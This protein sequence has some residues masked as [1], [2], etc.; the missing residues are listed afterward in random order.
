MIQDLFA[1]SVDRY[2]KNVAILAGDASVTYEEL[3]ENAN[4]LANR[5]LSLG[6]MKGDVVAILVHNRVSA[7]MSIVATLK[8]GMAFV[9]LDPGI[10]TKRL[11]LMI[12]DIR[13]RLFLVESSMMTRLK[14][15]GCIP[16][17]ASLL[18]LDDEAPSDGWRGQL[19]VVSRSWKQSKAERPQVAYGPD[20]MCYI[21]FT[22][23]STGRPKPIAGRL[24]GIDHFIK[25][26]IETLGLNDQ[27]RGSQLLPLS[28]DPS[29]REI[30]APL[31]CGGTVCVPA[32]PQVL[33][34]ASALADWINRQRLE[35]AQFVPSLLRS[36]LSAQLSQDDF[37]SLKYVLS[38]GE[39]LLPGDVGKWVK[40]F[41]DRI[42][43]VN[44][45]GP[46][47]T[48]MAKFFY[49]VK[50]SDKDKASIPIGKPMPGA[51]AVVVGKD[52]A[53]C[54]PKVIGEIYIRTPYRSLGYYN[55]PE[56]TKQVFVQNP[57]SDESEDLV[58]KSGD[59]GRILDDGNFECLGRKDDQVKIRGV[60]IELREIEDCLLKHEDLKEVAVVDREDRE[61]QKYLCA[62]VV[63][64]KEVARGQLRKYLTDFFPE[65]MVPSQIVVMEQLPLTISGKVDRR[66]LP[67]PEN[68]RGKRKSAEFELRTPVE[69]VLVGIWKEVLGVR[70]LNLDDDFFE[71]GGHS[72]LATQ[73]LSR[74]RDVFQVAIPLKEIFEDATVAALA[75]AVERERGIAT[76]RKTPPIQHAGRDQELP[77]SF[78]Q[79]RLW[80]LHQLA[81]ADV[82]YNIGQ[83]VRLPGE[84][85]IHAIWQGLLELVNRHEVLRTRFEVLN[86]HPVQVIEPPRRV[87]LPLWDISSLP[88]T[89][90]EALA[91]T[92][93]WAVNQRPFDLE[94]GPVWRAAVLRKSTEDHLMPLSVHHVANDGW[95]MVLLVSEFKEI[96][97]PYHEG[98][99]PALPEL[100]FQY[101][102]FSAW[103][104]EWLQ[105]GV[106]ADLLEYWKRQLAEAPVL[107][108]PRNSLRHIANPHGARVPFRLS[109]NLN[110]GLTKLSRQVGVTTFMTLLAGLQIVLA[111]YT[112]QE[113]IAI[114]VPIAGRNRSDLEKVVGLFV[115]TLVM[116][117][118]VG[119]NPT[120]RELLGRVRHV[121][122]EAYAHQDA[123][124]EKVVEELRPGRSLGWDDPFQ[125][126][127]V[128]QNMPAA[129][130]DAQKRRITGDWIW[131][132]S[133]KFAMTLSLMKGE[134]NISGFLEY[135]E[136]LFD[137]TL[138]VR[139]LGHLENIFQGMLISGIDRRVK[140]IRMLREEEEAQVLVEWSDG[141]ER[142]EG[143]GSLGELFEAQVERTPDAAA[144]EYEDEEISYGE[145]NERGEELA[146]EL[147]ELGV[148]GEV[149]VGICME[150]GLEMMVG[151]VGVMKAGGSYVAVEGRNPGERVRSILEDAGARVVVTD[152]RM[153][154]R[155]PKTVRAVYVGRGKR[156]GE[157]ETRGK[158]E[159]KGRRGGVISGNEAYVMYT[160]GSTGRARGVVI[161]Q[162]GVINL[163]EAMAERVYGRGR[164]G[165]RV[166]L[167]ASLVFDASVKQI[168]RLMYGDK[169][170]IV[171]ESIRG[172]GE[173]LKRFLS[174]VPGVD[175]FDCTPTQIRAVIEAGGGELPE[176]FRG[177]VVIGGEELDE[178]SVEAV[179]GGEWRKCHNVYGPTECTNTA[180][181]GDMKRGEEITI[182]RPLGGVK[183]YVV[184]SEGE[185]VPIGVKGELNIGGAG[186]ARGY[187]GEAR[188]T[189]VRFVPDRFGGRIGGRVYRTGDLVSWEKKGQLRYEGRADEQ[190]KIRGYRVEMGEIEKVLAEHAG[191]RECAVVARKNRRGD[192]VLVG[193]FVVAGERKLSGGELREYLRS[194]LPE[195]MVPWEYVEL[196]GLP[197][198]VNR[199]L[200]RRELKRKW[201]EGQE[202]GRK[203]KIE[204]PTPVE[205]MLMEMW[206]EV[207]G[208]DRIGREEN[209]FELG[210]HSLL[211]TQVISRVRKMFEVEV[212]LT[213]L[214]ERPTIAG[215][216]EAVERELGY[217][218]GLKTGAIERVSREG[219]ILLS[220]SQQRMWFLQELEPES[221]AYN[222][223]IG[224]RIGGRF[225]ISALEQSLGEVVRRHEVLRTRFEC[226]EGHAAQVIDEE[227]GIGAPIVDLSAMEERHRN[228]LA[229]RLAQQEGRRSF[230]L[231][232]DPPIRTE[233]IR[234]DSGDNLL[235]LTLHHI[236][237]DG[238]ST[239][240][241]VREVVGLYKAWRNGER[242]GLTPLAIQYA[243]YSAWQ[244]SWLTR[245]VL[246]DQIEYWKQQLMDAPMLELPADRAR[247]AI[248]SHS[249]NSVRSNLPPELCTTLREV[250]RR[251]GVTLFMALLA[252]FQ[253]LLTRYT[254]RTDITVGSPVAGR[255]RAET[256]GLIGC[257]AN[258]LAMRLDTS[259]N[260]L[261]G[262]LLT[263]MRNVALAA[264]AH[265]DVP[266]EMVVEEVHPERSLSHEP[267][268]QAMFTMQPAS[269]PV[270]GLSECDI[271]YEAIEWK[272]SKLDIAMAVTEKGEQIKGRL[273][274]ATDL[275]D[276]V[277][278]ERFLGHFN[279]TLRWLGE[280]NGRG[281]TEFALMTDWEQEQVLVEWNRTGVEYEGPLCLPWLFEEQAERG[282]DRVAIVMGGDQVTYAALNERANQLGHYLR[283][284][285][286]RPEGRVGIR[287]ERSIS[288]LVAMLA[289]LKA[290]GAYVPLDPKYPDDRVKYMLRD[291]EVKI[292]IS[293]ADNEEV[294]E[295]ESRIKII[296][297][298]RDRKRIDERSGLNIGGNAEPGSLAYVI[299][300]SGS[301]GQPKGV[302]IT[303]GGAT[304]FLKWA[305]SAYPEDSLRAVLGSTSI[306]FDL[307]IFELFLPLCFGGKIV[308]VED[309]LDSQH[310][311]DREQVILINTV[312]S[313]LEGLLDLCRLPSCMRVVNVAGEALSADLVKRV[314]SGSAIERMH[315]LYGPT[316]TTT[317]STMKKI[318][319]SLGEEPTI[320]KPI[321]N[322]ELFVLDRN[323]QPVP[324]GVPGEIYIG[325]LG[326][327]RGYLNRPAQ[328]GERFVPKPF[329]LEAGTR[330]YRTG[331]VGRFGQGSEVE[332]LGRLDQQV[333]IRGYRIEPGEIET[334]LSSHTA[335]QQSA[336]VVRENGRGNKELIAYIVPTNE[337]DSACNDVRAYMRRKLPSYMVPSAF[338]LLDRMPLTPNGKL[339]RDALP[340]PKPL[341]TAAHVSPRTQVQ[342]IV[343]G[344]WG[345]LL[346]TETVGSDRSFFD[347]GGHSLL[348]TQ[349]ISRV[350]D[351][352]G[353]EVPLR[354]LFNTPTISGF[355]EAVE[356]ER[357]AGRNAEA[358]PI[359]PVP[360]DRTWPLSFAQQRLWF[361]QQLE[362]E[363]GLYN[364]PLGAHIDGP[365]SISALR[366][367]LQEVA[368]RHQ[369]LRTRFE[370]MGAGPV[371]V[372]DELPQIDLAVYDLGAL[373][374]NELD[375][376][377]RDIAQREAKRPFDLE[378]G[379]VWRAC[380][381]RCAPKEHVMLLYMHHVAGDG[382]SMG[383]L[384]KEITA[385]YDGY[386]EGRTVKLE[387]IP[388]QYV[389]YAMWQR[390]WL[391]GE[392]LQGAIDYWRHQLAGLSS[393]TLPTDHPRVVSARHK[394][395]KRMFS[396]SAD[397][398]NQIR[399]MSR[400]EGTTVFMTLLAAL[401]ALLGRYTGQD[402]VVVGT[403]VANRNR[404]ETEGLI[405]FFV[406][407]VVLRTDLS[408]N[409]SFRELLG[410]VRKTTLDAYGYQE[411]PFDRVVE[412]LNPQRSL[413]YTPIFQV[414]FV[415]EDARVERSVA[416]KLRLSPFVV[417]APA[418]G[419]DWVVTVRETKEGFTGVWRYREELFEPSTIE[420]ICLQ[421]QSLLDK[422]TIFPEA[423]LAELYT[424]VDA[425][426]NSRDESRPSA[427]VKEA[428]PKTVTLPVG[429]LVTKC[430]LSAGEDAPLVLNPDVEDFDP[431]EWAGMERAFI[432]D[433]LLE[434]GAILFRGFQIGSATDFERFVSAICPDLFSSYGDL[435]REEIGGYVYGSTPYPSDQPI[436]FHNESSHMHCWPLKIWFYCVTPPEQGGETPFVDC[437][438]LYEDMDP[439]LRQQFR[440]KGLMYVRNFG[441]GLDVS[442]QEFFKTTDPSAV[443]AFCQRAAIDWE[444]CAGSRLRTRK[445]CPAVGTHPKTGQSVFF[446]QLQ[447]HHISCLAGD[448]R[449]DLLNLFGEERLPR[450]VYYG[451][452]QR[453]PDTVVDELRHLYDKHAR[454][455]TWR[456]GDILMLDN[457]L[458]AH[459]RRPFSG[460][461]RI[462]VA[463]GEMIKATS[464]DPASAAV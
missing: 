423:S 50:P 426:I 452:G 305:N 355:A 338:V 244:R 411:L 4:R 418:R 410:R 286:L 238:W 52:G 88:E 353:V 216:R 381:L 453:I 102:D 199:K 149:R 450:N 89:E 101:A 367:S 185:A 456:A 125:I 375:E 330:M 164:R 9:P 195:Y 190:V 395:A 346:G 406:N 336:V 373:E 8:A 443:Q 323:C 264:Y 116:R 37:H 420:S 121:A 71:V 60:R 230:R 282:G 200:D 276:T 422:I 124:F 148:G 365:M 20:D 65:Y 193:Y 296:G 383:I 384:M 47:E 172:D 59:M 170:V 417:D 162:G 64:K 61:G 154:G 285:G 435:P 339:D 79:Q 233:L 112:G 159:R 21:Y 211:A 421:Y 183:V 97:N 442:W 460:P 312:P 328:T 400:C 14:G 281:L 263:R 229:R 273:E 83:V 171:P 16:P 198:T 110:E 434:H 231:D 377:S 397:L 234:I 80:F 316:E 51:R 432:E 220:Y 120:I 461:R 95:S 463:M 265:Q 303:L 139:M 279:R 356:R 225:D 228:E 393:G 235:I 388:V 48:T 334:I 284:Q 2:P 332:Y 131:S 113:D 106:L 33:L 327:A 49:F 322:T 34:D 117:T 136:A 319:G 217:G 311:L 362:P 17:G 178:G 150:R 75:R 394:N 96:Y 215:L 247:P 368:Q 445:R 130:A 363:S 132:G 440:N 104:R 321:A 27:S 335:V 255:N 119:G 134:K 407:Q 237:S 223:P 258:T 226:F 239:Q 447:A 329:G 403:D 209:F 167:N 186:V 205:E 308:M 31:C 32:D 415:W 82:A 382:W 129:A 351:T 345:V 427:V 290:G 399:R 92:L 107:D 69:E 191:I 448:V 105:G 26:E 251:N 18:C 15:V 262:E 84:V 413:S 12:D 300:T 315:N 272:T 219:E 152:E 66:A 256:E 41:R 169:L 135:A 3:E 331:D 464:Y 350:R 207:L 409:P 114:G 412:T 158:G 309:L 147:R 252:G 24:K 298:E 454:S 54:P 73:V 126:M 391:R 176:T 398:S 293:G 123:P 254:G 414:L 160:S 425:S 260:P 349:V 301:T 23:G 347:L 168:I 118:D 127:F 326:L 22:S 433:N 227:F 378:L 408:G 437:R 137:R 307:S 42:Q 94:K 206:R 93:V 416:T 151:L 192:K 352:L 457:M 297:L 184:D 30:F 270:D 449:Q 357:K 91:R 161:E 314:M 144:V 302:G 29:L 189:A 232:V 358:P 143:A 201:A 248:A 174:E 428:A 194:R 128:F 70:N 366:Q 429:S 361:I 278:I 392:V 62:Y 372:I 99:R 165:L 72:L 78:A 181:W 68:V 306:S 45:Y 163:G 444:W 242:S 261:P 359:R 25:W 462:L 439:G 67:T 374:A 56:L 380:L 214:F 430:Y 404:L 459:G 53:P 236:A 133:T 43:L 10:P 111:R 295:D 90:R 376:Q 249:G 292:L 274:Y 277:R 304:G 266:F 202:E 310:I 259:G 13:P 224:L 141:G 342:E 283:E 145:L 109:P 385:L 44:L 188:L 39:P 390:E 364:I 7:I 348:A 218:E 28:F 87:C 343:A 246:R 324:V 6:L 299:Y 241:M 222:I 157:R 115:N 85:N 212:P 245:G 405:G 419:F 389:D 275:Y 155:L 38:C 74:I 354:A 55:Q 269:E 40:L 291:A 271:S 142:Y 396:I 208:K 268:F 63:L 267:L 210:G 177:E 19:N 122:L 441:D 100:A 446:N 341:D 280:P 320:G 58:Y 386:S 86:G 333:K 197:V 138:I 77:L 379:P 289:T 1:A 431:I 196:A 103:Q 287:L 402:D 455:F 187:V 182:G 146:D 369:V 153:A 57:F 325:G 451:D 98:K 371:Q 76:L 288:M 253:V 436:L 294:H 240:I 318:E 340:V 156:R 438:R 370:D 81:P 387:E 257:F 401:Q 166:S 175:V 173:A 46:S 213:E 250:S 179:L 36:L 140:E 313:A 458:V 35:I 204:A 5:L 221:V 424:M 203:E 317:Y 180:T 360:R 11:E 337:D 108:L 344:I 243:D